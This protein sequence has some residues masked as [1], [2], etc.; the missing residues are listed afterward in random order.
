MKFASPA[1]AVNAAWN[2]VR[3]LDREARAEYAD[4]LG[5]VNQAEE[6]LMAAEDERDS[7][8]TQLRVSESK[9]VRNSPRPALHTPRSPRATTATF[10]TLRVDELAAKLSALETSLRGPAPLPPP[11]PMAGGLREDV[12]LL[13]DRLASLEREVDSAATPSRHG[14]DLSQLAAMKERLESIELGFALG[15]SAPQTTTAVAPRPEDV[16]ALRSR[17]AAV[18]SSAASD[19]LRE[20]T[21]RLRARLESLEAAGAGMTVTM[22]KSPAAAPR[23]PGGTRRVMRDIETGEVIVVDQP[24]VVSQEEVA[25]KERLAMLEGLMLADGKLPEVAAATSTSSSSGAVVS[26]GEA[27]LKERL[28]MIEGIKKAQDKKKAE[29]E[30]E[31]RKKKEKEADEREKAL[32]AELAMREKLALLEGMELQRRIDN[33]EEVHMPMLSPARPAAADT[34]AAT[35]EDDAMLQRIAILEGIA[36]ERG[37]LPKEI[38]ASMPIKER[39]AMLEGSQIERGRNLLRAEAQVSDE[40]LA[41]RERLAIL[42]GREAAREAGAATTTATHAAPRSPASYAR[43]EEVAILHTR[44]K[45]LRGMRGENGMT[46]KKVQLISEEEAKLVERLGFLEGAEIEK[47][48]KRERDA[49]REKEEMIMQELQAKAAEELRL[50]ERIAYLEGQAAEREAS[51]VQA[52]ELALRERLASL[53]GAVAEKGLDLPFEPLPPLASSAAPSTPGTVSDTEAALRERIAMLEGAI[54]S[55]MP[56]QYL[57]EGGSPLRSALKSPRRTPGRSQR[58]GVTS[59]E[60][61]LK[62]RIA[63]LEGMELAN[64][65]SKVHVAQDDDEVSE[66]EAVLKERVALLEGMQ[67]ARQQAEVVAEEKAAKK[68]EDAH[69]SKVSKRLADL[70]NIINPPPPP[71]VS[72]EVSVIHERIDLLTRAV[73]EKLGKSPGMRTKDPD[74]DSI[75]DDVVAHVRERTANAVEQTLRREREEALQ[76]VEDAL[77]D[78]DHSRMRRRAAARAVQKEH[79]AIASGAPPMHYSSAVPASAYALHSPHHPVS[80]LSRPTPVP[81]TLIPTPAAPVILTSPPRARY[82]GVDEVPKY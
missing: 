68:E 57:R 60:L 73:E 20:E 30:E 40:E 31:E 35:A 3:E 13:R 58:R 62:E 76:A 32:K 41:L 24:K 71:P 25:L 19:T 79:D 39:I 74:K 9:V 29:E 1:R 18:E 54:N 48:A 33:G 64:S 53:E 23:T 55:A 21:V 4:L 82:P 42:E 72:A 51:T 44:V 47:A 66:V 50:R 10:E 7:L 70:E 52:S 26:E 49:E 28:A 46:P 22:P 12:R 59:E 14:G 38:V 5:R 6:R 63:M 37:N 36:I 78:S 15:A 43:S 8:R 27:S 17:L 67:M 69:I 16:A 81:Y 45:L 65:A 56:V 80:Y 34:S 2:Q 75:V 11:P 77:D 61:R